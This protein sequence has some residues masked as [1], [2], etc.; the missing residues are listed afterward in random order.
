MN[1]SITDQWIVRQL[2]KD[3]DDGFN[4]T[5]F[6]YPNGHRKPELPAKNGETICAGVTDVLHFSTD[7][8][9]VRDKAG[10]YTRLPW[11]EIDDF[12]WVLRTVKGEP[13]QAMRF[14]IG[15]R[16]IVV[17]M[18][19]DFVPYHFGEV[20]DACVRELTAGGKT[21]KLPGPARLAAYARPVPSD[22][23]WAREV[24]T[25]RSVWVSELTCPCGSGKGFELRYLGRLLRGRTVADGD[26]R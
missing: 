13:V 20:I 2:R 17:P 4:E 19:F 26:L 3:K 14:H 15:R 1:A 25:G 9:Y 7:A 16:T 6:V 18:P 5:T 23:P 22:A 11:A 21:C 24:R 8:V 10:G 12:D